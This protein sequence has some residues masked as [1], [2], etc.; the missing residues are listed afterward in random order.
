MR[1]RALS[2]LIIVLS[3]A[4]VAS[5]AKAPFT[6]DALL[7]LS[8]IDDPQVSPNGKT[9]AFVVQTVDLPANAKPSAVYTVPVDGGTPVRLTAPGNSN[10]RPRWSPDSRRIFFISDRK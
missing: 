8:R 2:A 3:S 1:K 5:G 7:S 6:V 4:V 9:V 10:Y